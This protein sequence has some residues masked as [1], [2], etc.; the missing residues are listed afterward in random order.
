MVV[1][2]LGRPNSS[3]KQLKLVLWGNHD[4]CGK[5]YS[6]NI[7]SMY[8]LPC[9]MKILMKLGMGFPLTLGRILKTCGRER[10]SGEENSSQPVSSASICKL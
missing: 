3:R 2:W 5:N 9:Y 1:S 6:D 7:Y 8:R 4:F 10:T